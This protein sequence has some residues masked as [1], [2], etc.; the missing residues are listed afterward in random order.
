MEQNENVYTRF[1]QGDLWKE[2]YFV[3]F[4]VQKTELRGTQPLNYIPTTFYLIQGLTKIAEIGLGILILLS[5]PLE[6]RRTNSTKGREDC[7][8]GRRSYLRRTRKR[9]S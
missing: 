8:W 4:T 3:L 1:I 5:Q 6:W 2:D 9:S 7:Y